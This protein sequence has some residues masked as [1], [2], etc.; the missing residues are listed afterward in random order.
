R[1]GGER[2]AGAGTH[3]DRPVRAREADPFGLGGPRGAD[4]VLEAP[5]GARADARRLSRGARHGW[6]V[7]GAGRRGARL[8]LVLRG[9]RAV[10]PRGSAAADGRVVRRLRPAGERGG[11]GALPPD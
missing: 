7:R 1:F 5:P 9:R 2:R 11:G 8:T 10:P 6:P 3:P 4:R